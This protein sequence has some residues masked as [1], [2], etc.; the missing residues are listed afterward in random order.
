MS[1]VKQMSSSE[2]VQ[3][4]LLTLEKQHLKPERIQQ[5]MARLLGW[6]EGKDA[7]GIYRTR[8]FGSPAEAEAYSAF[9]GKVAAGRRQAV[10]LTLAGKQVSVA[11]QGRPGRT[12]A[13]ITDAGYA[14]ACV[15]G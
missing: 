15:L 10:T 1:N 11:I 5:Q 13:G 12:K 6:E 4:I 3:P 7:P 14:L 9:A 8:L 2:P